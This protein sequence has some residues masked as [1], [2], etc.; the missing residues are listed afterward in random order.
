M[1]I[2]NKINEYLSKKKRQTGDNGNPNNFELLIKTKV[3]EIYTRKNKN[4][5]LEDLNYEMLF[6]DLELMKEAIKEINDVHY[7]KEKEKLMITI[8]KN[9]KE[10]IA[11]EK[12][13]YERWQKALDLYEMMIQFSI[14]LGEK[15]K[16][17]L[18][19]KNEYITDAK[20]V[21]L[22]KIHSR[23]ILIG[24]EI[25]VLLKAGYIDGAHA[26]WRS[27]HE[28]AVISLFLL[29]NETIVS[30]RYLNHSYIRRAFESK[31][32]N[33]Y[34]SKTG[35]APHTEEE[36]KDFEDTREKLEEKYGN[37][38]DY[39]GGFGWIPTSITKNR[40]FKQLEKLS[41]IDHLRPYYN[42]SSNQVHG[43]AH[44]FE[45]LGVPESERNN[46][47]FIGP[48]NHGVT[49]PIHSASLS[50]LHTT[51]AFLSSE[52]Y[53]ELAKDIDLLGRFAHEVGNKALEVTN[54]F[55]KVD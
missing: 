34:S 10:L 15:Q 45:Y 53:L 51:M 5:N 11:F 16:R 38:Y 30:E 2:F 32:F 14:E 17:R 36:L 27:M 46:I 20:Y 9:R 54:E 8:K 28:L 55:E 49:D 18:G 26:R 13:H 40:N 47:L 43:G 22:L 4:L 37:D 29:N 42:W 25:L 21:A 52:K 6:G 35:Y 3:L 7:G 44:G 23:S 41:G 48:S 33:E 31:D 39:T 19:E 12:R 24:R 50:L 1:L